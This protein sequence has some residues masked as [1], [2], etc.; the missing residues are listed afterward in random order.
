[1]LGR[2]SQRTAPPAPAV[3]GDS[4]L[5]QISKNRLLTHDVI[6]TLA[7]RTAAREDEPKR[8]LLALGS[9]RRAW[10]AAR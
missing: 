1:M 8:L 7:V 10:C 6:V 2:S 3:V 9:S 4:V 5:V